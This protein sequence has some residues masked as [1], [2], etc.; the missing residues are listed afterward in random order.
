[1]CYLA[2]VNKPV[3]HPVKA[4]RRMPRIIELT[5]VSLSA[6]VLALPILL[7]GLMIFIFLGRPVFFRQ[8]RIGKLKSQFNILKFRTMTN[9]FGSDGNLLPDELRQTTFTRFIRRVRL[10]ELPQILAI[11]KG[12]MALVGPRPLLPV[13]ID[14]FGLLGERRCLVK[15]GLTGWSQVSGNVHLSNIEKLKLDLWYVNHR[16][17]FLDVKII[18]ETFTVLLF[19]EKVNNNRINTADMWLSEENLGHLIEAKKGL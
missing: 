16:S 6:L 1:M 10:D 9:E 13:T 12:D 2:G 8:P 18:Y 5:L 3:S 17:L 7:T 4:H 14:E 11:L 15:P 19:G